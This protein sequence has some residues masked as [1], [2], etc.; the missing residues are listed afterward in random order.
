MGFKKKKKQ[1]NE[2]FR[3][4]LGLF[5]VPVFDNKK[6]SY[7]CIQFRPTLGLFSV[8]IFDNNKKI[9]RVWKYFDGT[10]INFAPWF[11]RVGKQKMAWLLLAI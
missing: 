2:Q 10:K 8:P 9:L 5:S 4:T 6:K 1:F 11:L 3:P 7:T